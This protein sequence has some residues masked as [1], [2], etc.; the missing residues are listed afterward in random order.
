MGFS[1]PVRAKDAYRLQWWQGA[2]KPQK[3][4]VEA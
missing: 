2:G 4:R 1:L 3:V